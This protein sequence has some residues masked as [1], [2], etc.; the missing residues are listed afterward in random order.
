MGSGG[1]CW[2]GTF[3]IRSCSTCSALMCGE[4]GHGFRKPDGRWI[5]KTCESARY[6]RLRKKSLDKEVQAEDERDIKNKKYRELPQASREDVVNFIRCGHPAI[7]DGSSHQLWDVTNLDVADALADV[8]RYAGASETDFIPLQ[9]I[10]FG[11]DNRWEDRLYRDGRRVAARIG[12][13]DETPESYGHL[14]QSR[15]GGRFNAR[16][17]STNQLAEK[18]VKLGGSG[19]DLQVLKR[20]RKVHQEAS[21]KSEEAQRRRKDDARENVVVFALRAGL[22]LG[23]LA[24]VVFLVLVLF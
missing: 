9:F 22:L 7:I 8:W 2:C 6:Q 15:P 14:S 10:E 13:F 19:L 24:V 5:C 20:A 23:I 18:I 12:W 11:P 4:K 1:T 16:A 17:V 21:R 3:A